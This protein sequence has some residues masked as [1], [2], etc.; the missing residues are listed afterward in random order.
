MLIFN[1]RRT[2]VGHH[3]LGQILTFNNILGTTEI[4]YHLLVYLLSFKE[5]ELRYQ[6]LVNPSAKQA[7]MKLGGVHT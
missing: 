5:Q 2:V 1:F 3:I 6:H 4:C 7:G